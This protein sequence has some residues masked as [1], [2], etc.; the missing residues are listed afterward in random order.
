MIDENTL[1][2]VRE[3]GGWFFAILF[4]M[5]FR[6]KIDEAITLLRE[7]SSR[8]PERPELAENPV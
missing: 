3:F 4:Y 1:E 2:L 6:K 5:D 8:G 7:L